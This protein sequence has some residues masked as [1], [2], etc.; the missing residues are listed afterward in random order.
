M[1]STVNDLIVLKQSPELFFHEDYHQQFSEEIAMIDELY[2]SGF[3]IGNNGTF[4]L[5]NGTCIF[6]GFKSSVHSA[7]VQNNIIYEVE[8][9][10][11]P[12]LSIEKI[13]LTPIVNKGTIAKFTIII[14]NLG[15]VY[16]ISSDGIVNRPE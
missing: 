10:P 11:T 1:I 7:P 3:R 8:E 5:D 6:I 14:K 15:D 2:E 13:T 12:D 4:K 16:K 9:V